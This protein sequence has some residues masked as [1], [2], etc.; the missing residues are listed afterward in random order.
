MTAL[1]SGSPGNHPHVDRPNWRPGDDD[2]DELKLQKLNDAFRNGDISE[3]GLAKLLGWNRT[4]IRRLKAMTQIPEPL[5]DRLC[6]AWRSGTIRRLSVKSWAA[7]GRLIREM[8]ERGDDA[9]LR[10]EV[11]CCPNCGHTLRVRFDVEPAALKIVADWYEE[12]DVARAC[13]E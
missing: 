2:V 4:K 11:E 1:D 10:G 3:R 12:Q 13:D 5:R 6:E 7:V 8:D 9:Q